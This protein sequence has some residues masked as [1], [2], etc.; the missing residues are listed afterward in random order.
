[1]IPTQAACS[2]RSQSELKS[3]AMLHNTSFAS[4]L[5]TKKQIMTKQW[6]MRMS[7]GGLD[8]ASCSIRLTT[9]LCGRFD[10]TQMINMIDKWMITSIFRWCNHSLLSILNFKFKQALSCYQRSIAQGGCTWESMSSTIILYRGILPSPCSGTFNRQN[11]QKTEPPWCLAL[12]MDIGGTAPT[13]F[14]L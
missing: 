14:F 7:G 5:R 10:L 12:R 9:H 6:L 13:F 1:M 11:L 3:T 8:H 2:M 4:S